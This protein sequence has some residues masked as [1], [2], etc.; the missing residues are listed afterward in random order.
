MIALKDSAPAVYIVEHLNVQDSDS[1]NRCF[2]N[3]FGFYSDVWIFP[4]GSGSY[5]LFTLK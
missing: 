1:F 4:D 5:A 2:V 3:D